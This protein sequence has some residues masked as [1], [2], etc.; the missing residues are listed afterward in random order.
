[1]RAFATDFSVEAPAKAKMYLRKYE[2]KERCIDILRQF[3]DEFKDVCFSACI[4]DFFLGDHF[5]RFHGTKQ[6]VEPDSS[7][8]KGRLLRDQCQLLAVLLDIELGDTFAVELEREEGPSM[9]NTS[10]C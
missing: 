3:L 9:G 4:L 10:A 6:D 7:R 2:I 1:L 5:V 8:V